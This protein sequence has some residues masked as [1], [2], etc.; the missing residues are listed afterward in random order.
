MKAKDIVHEYENTGVEPSM[1]HEEAVQ[2]GREY[3]KV[4]ADAIKDD[5]IYSVRAATKSADKP[6]ASPSARLGAEAVSNK[7]LV[8][9]ILGNEEEAGLGSREAVAF[10]KG[11][12]DNKRK[13]IL[14][15][16]RNSG[17]KRG[18]EIAN[19]FTKE[20]SQKTAGDKLKRGTDHVTR[21]IEK[22]KERSETSGGRRERHLKEMAANL[23]ELRNSK[24]PMKTLSKLASNERAKT[25]AN[26]NPKEHREALNQSLRDAIYSKLTGLRLDRYLGRVQTQMKKDGLQFKRGGVLMFK[27]GSGGG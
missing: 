25:L 2:L 13:S 20:G 5:L 22:L 6:K 18:T 12:T 26:E 19:Y 21:A 17:N 11:L 24:D 10:L 14:S 9:Y 3:P 27:D 4:H 8:S 15:A 16:L 23:E 7:E 1:F